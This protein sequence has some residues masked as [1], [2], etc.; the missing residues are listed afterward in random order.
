MVTCIRGWRIYEDMTAPVTGRWKAV[1][2]GVRM[3]AS[4]Y[5]MLVNMIYQ[6]CEDERVTGKFAP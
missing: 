2:Y 6:R 4:T 3:G 1:R 5:E